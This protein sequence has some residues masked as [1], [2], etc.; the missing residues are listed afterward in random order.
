MSDKLKTLN[1]IR[2]IR[3]QARAFAL[4][5]LEEMLEKFSVVVSERREAESANISAI[6]E[7]NEQIETYRI[8]LLQDGIAPEE[9]VT[10]VSVKPVKARKARPAKYQFV[11]EQGELR[12][13]TG[14]GRTPGHLQTQLNAGK[15]LADF[16][17]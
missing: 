16:L 2:T 7:R 9:L 15:S 13:W 17:I 6:R 4:P 14:Q 5:E 1:N 11:N 3:A 10:T 8:L 12:T